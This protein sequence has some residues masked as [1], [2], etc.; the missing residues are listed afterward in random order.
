MKKFEIFYGKDYFAT[1]E[2]D[3]VVV[4][5]KINSWLFYKNE[6]LVG[7]VPFTYLIAKSEDLSL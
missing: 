2:G 6:E 7:S 4:D 1:I 3:F 5:Y